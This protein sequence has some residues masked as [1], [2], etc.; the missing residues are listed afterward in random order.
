[1][2]KSTIL[3][4]ALFS[5]LAL[6]SNLTMKSEG[7]TFKT[8]T[9]EDLANMPQTSIATELPWLEGEN[10]FTGVSLIELFAQANAQIPDTITFIALNDYKVAITLKDI[11]AYNP[12]VANRKN[13]EKMSVRD[14]GPFWVIFPISQFPEI[15]TTDYH[16]MMIWQLKEVSY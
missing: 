2:L 8:Y 14:K 6:A 11:Q 1:M 12:I 15:D 10:H 13:G 4:F 5:S 9:D 7:V 3:L 16:S